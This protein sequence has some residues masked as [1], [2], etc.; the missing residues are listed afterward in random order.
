MNRKT[1]IALAHLAAAQAGADEATRRAAQ[2][3]VTG[4]AS[5]RDMD[6]AALIRLIRYWQRCGA[7]VRL[8]RR[9]EDASSDRAPLIRKLAAQCHAL[10]RP[11]PAYA[12][13][14]L[15]QM[16]CAVDRIEWVPSPMLRKAVAALAYQQKREKKA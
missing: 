9:P 3:K 10:A 5:C 14:V 7:R 1:L 15:K 11:Y 16:G 13:G 2:K 4:V 12:L 6:E 8:P